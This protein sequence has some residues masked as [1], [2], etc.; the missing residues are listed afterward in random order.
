[1]IGVV[2]H[3]GWQIEGGRQSGL[4]LREQIAEA[5]I[6]VLRRAKAGELTH[7]PQPP[8]VHRRMNAARVRGLAGIAE[9]AIRIPAGKIGRSVHA[10]NRKAG[11][12]GELRLTLGIFFQCRPQR[13]FFPGFLFGGRRA[14]RGSRLGRCY[15]LRC[16]LGMIAH[17]QALAHPA[18]AAAFMLC[19]RWRPSKRCRALVA[20]AIPPIGNENGAYFWPS[21]SGNRFNRSSVPTT[22]PCSVPGIS[23]SFSTS[24]CLASA[25]VTRFTS[26]V[27][28]TARSY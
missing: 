24:P 26:S 7:G 1:M 5:L 12:G 15:G 9:I 19:E 3:Q 10:L 14:V 25:M 8:A 21:P 22:L 4:P 20:T 16:F 6:G 13:I 11:N 17:G 18:A 28:A 23:V 2:A 27:R